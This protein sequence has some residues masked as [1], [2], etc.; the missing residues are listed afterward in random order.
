MSETNRPHGSRFRD[1]LV[2]INP[3][4]CNPSGVALSIADA[5]SEMHEHEKVDTKT[6]CLDPAIRLMVYQ[7]AHLFGGRRPIRRRPLHQRRSRLQ[8]TPRRTRPEAFRRRLTITTPA[9][10]SWQGLGRWK[11]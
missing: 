6:I 9:D 11:H 5:C 10:R 2:V 8:G 1:A 4:S 7:L 3:G